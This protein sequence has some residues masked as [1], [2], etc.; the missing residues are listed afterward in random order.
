MATSGYGNRLAG[1][2]QFFQG[3]KGPGWCLA[4]R[5]GPTAASW[6]YSPSWGGTETLPNLELLPSPPPSRNSSPEMDPSL[7]RPAPIAVPPTPELLIDEP[8]TKRLPGSSQ[9]SPS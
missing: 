3:P 4:P 2:N 8:I 5:G 7:L 6:E 9:E 1:G